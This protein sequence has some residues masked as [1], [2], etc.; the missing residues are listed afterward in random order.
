M[1]FQV[2]SS[3]TSRSACARKLF[4]LVAI[5]GNSKTLQVL[6]TRINC[7]N[8]HVRVCSCPWKT[9]PCCNTVDNG[10]SFRNVVVV[11]VRGSAAELQPRKIYM[12]SWCNGA[13]LRGCLQSSEHA[14]RQPI[15]GRKFQPVHISTACMAKISPS[16]IATYLGGVHV[17]WKLA[18]SAALV[19][20]GRPSRHTSSYQDHGYRCI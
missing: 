8:G 1:Y 10:R 9:T 4:E 19:S 5:G 17:G 11:T 3:S 14:A 2:I 13:T 20:M 6:C 18:S 15:S 12:R 7:E 16:A